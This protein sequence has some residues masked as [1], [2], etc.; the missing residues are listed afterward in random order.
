[1]NRDHRDYR[2][3][4]HYVNLLVP[5][6]HDLLSQIDLFGGVEYHKRMSVAVV[7]KD[8][9]KAEVLD[10][11]GLVFV[12]FHAEWCGPCKMTEPIIK[13][14]SDE[15]KDIKFVSVDVDA[16]ADVAAQYQVF[17]IPTFIILKDGKPAAQFVGAQGKESFLKE[18]EKARTS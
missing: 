13:E 1:V 2:E 4:A 17:S 12:D 14:I 18:I 16:N 15:I 7:T 11:K 10:Y 9:F 3:A 6:L 5:F 8:N